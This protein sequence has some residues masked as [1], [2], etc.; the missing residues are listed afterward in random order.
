MELVLIIKQSVSAT[1][2]GSQVTKAPPYEVHGLPPKEGSAR[3]IAITKEGL[4]DDGKG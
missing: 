3:R 4:P 1:L 2:V